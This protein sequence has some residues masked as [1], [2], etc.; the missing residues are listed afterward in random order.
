MRHRDIR[1]SDDIT[2]TV[3]AAIHSRD[4]TRYQFGKGLTA[5]TCGTFS[6]IAGSI[7]INTNIGR[8]AW[9]ALTIT[10]T[11]DIIDLLGSQYPHF[12]G[13]HGSSITTTIHVLDAGNSTSFNNHL[14]RLL[15]I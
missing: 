10:T 8:I 7:R 6:G 3:A 14:G 1:A 12:R 9:T 15:R 2:V 13:R 5:T 4:I 11:E